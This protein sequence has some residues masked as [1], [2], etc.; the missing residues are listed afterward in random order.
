MCTIHLSPSFLGAPSSGR[1]Q[2]AT[3]DFDL[4]SAKHLARLINDDAILLQGD[5]AG[6][7]T[8]WSVLW[9]SANSVNGH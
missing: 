5:M 7:E 6:A 1:T 2:K 8:F 4:D 9:A 3:V